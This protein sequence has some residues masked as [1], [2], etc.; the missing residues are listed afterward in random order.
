MNRNF[1]YKEKVEK[2]SEEMFIDDIL[3]K[4]NLSDSN[5]HFQEVIKIIKNSIQNNLQP[6]FFKKLQDYLEKFINKQ[7]KNIANLKLDN[8]EI[9]INFNFE[10]KFDIYFIRFSKY[11]DNNKCF[12]KIII[13][14]KFHENTFIHNYR[15]I[16]SFN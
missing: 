6:F 8:D 16:L 4:N 3:T 15:E 11:S 5:S 14:H 12:I 1:P 7:Y 10:Q 13:S 2:S 9:I